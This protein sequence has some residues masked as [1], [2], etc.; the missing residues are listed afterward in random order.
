MSPVLGAGG[1]GYDD[2][3]RI[4]NYDS[5]I[6]YSF[7]APPSASTLDSPVIPVLRWSYLEGILAPNT[8]ASQLTFTWTA[9]AGGFS[10]IGVRKFN[11][12]PLI[13]NPMQFRLSNLGPYVQVEQAPIAGLP[14]GCSGQMFGGNRQS[15]LEFVPQQ[16]TVLS[17]QNVNVVAGTSPVWYPTDYYAGPAKIWW[18][19]LYTSG[20]VGLQTLDTANV[21]EYTWQQVGGGIQSQNVD[22][23]VCPPGAWR[24]ITGNGS[25]ANGTLFVVV[26]QSMSGAV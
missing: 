4:Q 13:T 16:P 1:V 6:L 14:W 19:P 7:A 10:T 2:Y 15:L 23:I 5:A 24:L 26:A 3:Q 17:V 12:S 18:Q 11:I 8:N 20:V 21:W 9:D 22:T 25:G